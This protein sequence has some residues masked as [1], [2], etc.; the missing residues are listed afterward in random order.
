VACIIRLRKAS[1]RP[2]DQV[3]MEGIGEQ[4]GW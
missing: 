4:T 1:L 2:G 3:P